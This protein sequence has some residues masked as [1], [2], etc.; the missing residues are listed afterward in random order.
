M[1]P[2]SSDCQPRLELCELPP[3]EASPPLICIG[4]SSALLAEPEVWLLLEDAL[5]LLRPP[6]EMFSVSPLF[7]EELSWLELPWSAE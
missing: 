3:D 6:C 4:V 5:E 1:E 2:G 7:D